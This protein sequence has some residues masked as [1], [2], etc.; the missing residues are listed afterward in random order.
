V[1]WQALIKWGLIAFFIWWLAV[2]P[3]SLSHFLKTVGAGLSD[4]AHGLA[5]VLASL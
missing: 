1:N 3:A 2:E 5:T 4:L